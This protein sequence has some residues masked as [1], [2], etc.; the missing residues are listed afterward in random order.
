MPQLSQSG[1][2]VVV[3]AVSQG[4]IFYALPGDTDWTASINLSGEDP[5]LN[6]TGLV[7]SAA[8]NQKLWF[9]DGT[10]Y[11]YYDPSNNTVYP[12]LATAGTLPQDDDGNIPRL[13]APWRGG[14]MLSGIIGLPYAAFLTRRGDPTDF[15]YGAE[16]ND[17]AKAVAFT[18]TPSLGQIGDIVTCLIPYSDDTFIFGCDHTI[19]ILRGDP[20]AGGQLDYVTKTIGMAWGKPWC[21]GP[22]GT[23]YFFSNRMGVYSF[24]PGQQPVRMSQAIDA[25][26]AGVNT[27][28]NT[29]LLEWDDRFQGFHVFITPLDEPGA[30]VNYFWESRTN[31]WWPDVFANED[32]NPLCTCTVDGNEP[33][34][35]VV[36]LGSW[37]G[38]VRKLDPAA[39]D[40]DGTPIASSVV[41]GPILTADMD[42][43]MLKELQAVLAEASGSVSYKV[44]VGR[45]AEAALT[46]DPVTP[47]TWGASRNLTKAPRRSGHAIYFRLSSTNRW[48]MES[49]RCTV[50]QTLGKVRRRSY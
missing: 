11:V 41:I 5:P 29:I 46:N 33:D 50:V 21:Q 9:V 25:R 26:L 37:D 40:D 30:T 20:G 42:E 47:G 2:V 45:T 8:L 24:V 23:I 4:L 18:S 1:R 22:D 13:I 7:Y 12:W 10:N 14:L 34:D 3:T 49:V 16:A 15:D 44:L 19:V 39:E 38:Y 27:G 43:V 31:A 6:V 36:L 17:S 32:H 28:T 48:A 35:R